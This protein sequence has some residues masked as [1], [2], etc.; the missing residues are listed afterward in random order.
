MYWCFSSGSCSG[1][2]VGVD[3]TDG[4]GSVGDVDSSCGKSDSVGSIGGI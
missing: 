1:D 3:G 2:G 4:V